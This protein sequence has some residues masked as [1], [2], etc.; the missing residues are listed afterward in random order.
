[1]GVIVDAFT[2]CRNP[3]ACRDDGSVTDDR[4][5]IAMATGFNPNDAKAILGVVVSHP[6]DQSGQHIAIG[7][8]TI[9]LH[10]ARQS[11]AAGCRDRPCR[12]IRTVP[13]GSANRSL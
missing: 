8:R 13:P 7:W 3:L 1:M 12:L 4:D 10:R 11:A 2:R 6:L 5:K 9:N